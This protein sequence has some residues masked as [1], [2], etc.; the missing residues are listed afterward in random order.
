MDAMAML[1]QKEWKL[2]VE[3]V[4]VRGNTAPKGPCVC[5]V[6]QSLLGLGV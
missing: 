5:C 3:I 1:Q 4:L 2:C 6:F